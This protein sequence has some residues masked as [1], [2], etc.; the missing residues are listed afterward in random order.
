MVNVYIDCFV[1]SPFFFCYNKFCNDGL[2]FVIVFEI[3]F[4]KIKEK[5]L[6]RYGN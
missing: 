3:E 1:I 6:N 5:K 2:L 4:K